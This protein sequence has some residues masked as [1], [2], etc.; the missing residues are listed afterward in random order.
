MVPDLRGRFVRGVDAGKGRDPDAGSRTASAPN[1]NTGD[2]VGSL[3]GDLFKAH[4]HNM[5]VAKP[6]VVAG[7]YRK[8]N[9]SNIDVPLDAY[10]TSSTGG[11]ESRPKNIYVNWI[12]KAENL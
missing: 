5:A 1:R 2:K 11:N 9:I 3:Q 8:A 10:Q 6:Q 12:I 4:T 7:S